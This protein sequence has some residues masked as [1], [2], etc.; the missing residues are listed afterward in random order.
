MNKSILITGIA[1]SGK[2]TICKELKKHGY[3]TYDIEDIKGFFTMV[4]K[5]T[6]K[7]FHDYDNDNLKSIKKGHWICNKRKLQQLI[8]KNKKGIVFYCGTGS[9][10]E[11]VL[12]L[13]DKVILLKASQKTLRQRL[14]KRKTNDYGRTPEIQKWILSWKSRWESYYIKKGAIPINASRNLSQVVADILK[15]CNT[16]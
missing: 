6:G 15:R 13:F 3:K 7:S 2:S 5:N 10:I 8:R 12:P 14:S 16:L 1:G 4:N 11:E 9:N